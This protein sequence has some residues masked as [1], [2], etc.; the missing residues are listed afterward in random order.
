MQL[1]VPPG[2]RVRFFLAERGPLPCGC[3]QAPNFRAQHADF[4]GTIILYHADTQDRCARCGT[5]YPHPSDM[6]VVL[7]DCHQARWSAWAS[8]VVPL[9]RSEGDEASVSRAR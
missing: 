4:T 7:C 5:R 9:P 6:L 2:T 1:Q 3:D 8:E